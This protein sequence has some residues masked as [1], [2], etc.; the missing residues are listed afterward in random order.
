MF[1]QVGHPWPEPTRLTDP[2]TIQRRIRNKYEETSVLARWED[3]AAEG[4]PM[5]KSQTGHPHTAPTSNMEPLT[6]GS[7]G[8]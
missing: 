5:K 1:L 8:V 7:G 6:M 3:T 4:V 2:P